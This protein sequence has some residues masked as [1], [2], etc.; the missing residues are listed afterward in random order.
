MNRRPLI[1]LVNILQF[2]LG[3][4]LAG[5]AVYILRQI[6]APETIADPDAAA[7][8]R[9][10]VI[11]AVVMGVP[12]LVTLIAAWG[13][14]KGHFWGWALSLATDVGVLAVVL[15]NLFGQNNRGTSEPVLAAGV[16]LLVILLVVPSVRRFFWSPAASK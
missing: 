10:L 15:Y 13:M 8:Q 5:I 16:V 12:A 11:G 6:H 4:L 7:T 9:G 1:T 3:L 14:W 2:V